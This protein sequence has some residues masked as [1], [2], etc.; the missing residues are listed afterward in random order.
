LIAAPA[1]LVTGGLVIFSL[2]GYSR[3]GNKS[4]ID[5]GLFVAAFAPQYLGMFGHIFCN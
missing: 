2:W 4:W 1:A 3:L 5:L